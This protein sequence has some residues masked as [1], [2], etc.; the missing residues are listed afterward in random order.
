VSRLEVAAAACFALG[1]ALLFPFDRTLT[2]LF[3]VLL[4]FASVV[5]GVFVLASPER[6]AG[7]PDDRHR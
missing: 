6:L 3:G 7:E 1:V 2:I 4:L 5:C